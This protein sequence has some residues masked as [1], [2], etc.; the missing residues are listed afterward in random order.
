MSRGLRYLLVA[1]P[2]AALLS[3]APAA[4]AQAMHTL[5]PAAATPPTVTVTPSTELGNNQFVNITWGGV[6][7]LHP[8]FFRQCTETPTVIA[9]D[10]TALYGDTGFTGPSKSGTMYEYVTEGNVL[11]EDGKT[12]T[13]D[14]STPCSL[15]VFTSDTLASGTLVKITFAQTPD[16]CPAPVGAPIAGGGADEANRAMYNWEVKVCYPPINMGVNYI[17]ANSPDGKANFIKGLNDFAITGTPFTSTELGQLKKAHKTFTYAPI[18]ASGLVLAYKVFDL[19]QAASEPG[20]QVTNLKLTPE[21]IAK[22]FTG[23]ITDWNTDPDINALNPGNVFPSTVRPL[24]RGDHSEANLLFTSWLTAEGGSGLPSNWPGASLNY[25]LDYVTQNAAIVGGD[26]LA[27]AIA[28]PASVQNSTDYTAFGYIGFIDSSQAAYYGL[29]TVSIENASGNYVAA[30]PAS[31]TAALTA[32]KKNADGTV[33]PNFATT[34]PNAYP[35]P[36]VDYVTAPTDV[37]QPDRGITLRKF[38]NYAVTTGRTQVPAGYAPLPQPFV[39]QTLAAI[40]RIPDSA[41]KTPHHH[42]SGGG[43]TGGGSGTTTGGGNTVGDTSG[44]SFPPLG[45]GVTSPTGGGGSS[46]PTGGSSTG[47]GGG[48]SAAS[49]AVHTVS[50]ALRH[51]LSTLLGDGPTGLGPRL[52]VALGLAGILAGL[53]LEFGGR[54]RLSGAMARVRSRAHLPGWLQP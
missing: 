34:D 6:A 28:N 12:F 20:A 35:L 3:A 11:S 33:S 24:V 4:G 44:G 5:Q 1:A 39:K 17:P 7:A 27:N 38:L 18:A 2:L 42:R 40:S 13:C 14:V 51:P 54:H 52:L 32:A 37:I 10:C 19:D 53:L 15:G 45:S 48:G 30:T 9:D 26:T 41:P 29:P 46:A 47:G 49:T 50:A 36:L 23:Q 22:I 43:T 21:L 16:G 25:P 31:I 8:V